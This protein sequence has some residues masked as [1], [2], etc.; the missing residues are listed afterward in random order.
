MKMS[1]NMEISYSVTLIMEGRSFLMLR[2]MKQ[3]TVT[4]QSLISTDVTS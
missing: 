2:K 1:R 3:I 4:D